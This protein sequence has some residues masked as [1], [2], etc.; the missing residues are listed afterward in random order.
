MTLRNIIAK[1][2]TGLQDIF[3]DI[4]NKIF[5]HEN[6]GFFKKEIY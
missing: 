4:I 5:R 1:I 3:K 2:M 6:Q